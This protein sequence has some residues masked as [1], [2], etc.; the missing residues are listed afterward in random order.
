LIDRAAKRHSATLAGTSEQHQEH[1][2]KALSGLIALIFLTG[3][4]AQT[5]FSFDTGRSPGF[6][7]ARLDRIDDAIEA[8]I[9][10]GKIP[11]AVALISKDGRTVYHKSFGY[12]DIASQTAMRNDSIFRIAS[13][14]KAITTVGVMTLYEQGHFKLNDPISKYIP[15]FADP[16]V[17]V[18][19]DEDGVVT[20]TRPASREIRIIDLLTHSAGLGY[21]FIGTRLQKIYVENGIID[22]L[23]E[24]DVRLEEQMG[25]LAEMPLLFD[26]GSQWNYGLST[27]LLG[28]LIEVVSGMPLDQYFA[29]VIFTPLE[30]AD[31]HFYLP[32]NDFSR[33]VSLY[34]A[35]DDE[36]VPYTD[37]SMSDFGDTN[38]PRVGAMTY[39]SGGAGLSSTAYDYARFIEMLLND[40]EL[41]GARILGRKSVELMH[42]PR[43]DMDGDGEA[44]F[45]LGFQIIDDIGKSGELGSAGVYLWSGAFNTSYW[46]DPEENM[47]AVF[48]SQVRPNTSD[49]TTRFR[50]LVYQALK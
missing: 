44:E 3:C 45:G 46:I 40:G 1:F 7:E 4:A 17:L 39:F 12:A 9:A 22:G 29:D 26:P 27:D 38:Y 11:G 8:E 32:S 13:M 48:M 25:K 42:S 34:A 10:A 6:I 16:N 50:T 36:L 28:R 2:M 47:I 30:M 5:D 19:A 18:S 41:D 21:P 43:I 24:K 20:E 14:T 23:T 35:V 15:E 33:L 49:I 31:T 37:E